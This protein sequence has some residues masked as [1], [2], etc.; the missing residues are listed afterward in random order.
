[1]TRLD[2]K[3]RELKDVE[4][5]SGG[6]IRVDLLKDVVM[7]RGVDL[8]DRELK[9]VEVTRGGVRRVDMKYR[10]LKDGE[11]VRVGV[12]D[13]ELFFVVQVFVVT[14]VFLVIGVGVVFTRV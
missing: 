6:L 12:K 13:R 1:M 8:K 4:V 7:T 14:P 5:R 10:E 2:V 3:D 11:M 9:N